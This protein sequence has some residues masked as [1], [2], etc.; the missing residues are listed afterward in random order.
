MIH[1][2]RVR[3]A[4]GPISYGF[5]GESQRRFSITIS[6]LRAGDYIKE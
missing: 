1:Q 4:G 3:I 5:D 6:L 2:R